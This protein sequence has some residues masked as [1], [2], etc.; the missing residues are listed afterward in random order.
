[1]ALPKNYKWRKGD[2]V[3]LVGTV[4][5]DFDV[6]DPCPNQDVTVNIDGSVYDDTVKVYPDV[7]GIELVK[8]VLVVGD[9]AYDKISGCHGII[10]ALHDQWAWMQLR[11]TEGQPVSARLADLELAT[12]EPK[13]KE[14][15]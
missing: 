11:A 10:V 1:M 3:L 12:T 5:Y 8:P 6:N 2:K 9:L 4:E 14:A 15:A 7:D 13:E